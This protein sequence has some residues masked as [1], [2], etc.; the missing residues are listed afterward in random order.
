M[1]QDKFT[2][3][4]P[5]FMAK[6]LAALPELDVLSVAAIAGNLGHESGGFATLQE[7][8]PTV[9]GS[10][11]GY[12]WAQWTGPRR[13]AYEAWCAKKGLSPASDEA[14]MGYVI[15]ELLGPEKA[16]VAAVRRAGSKIR[17]EGAALA[18]KVKAFELAYERAG[19]KRYASRN[20]YATRALKN[21]RALHPGS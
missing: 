16:A 2:K 6:L 4:A 12:G 7:I 10:R 3:L 1:A 9:K 20:A 18:A 14:N 11:G 8:A 15:V 17:D 21:Y 13:R 19:I 5:I